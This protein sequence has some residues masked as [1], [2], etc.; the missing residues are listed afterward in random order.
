M[1]PEG[2]TVTFQLE[3]IEAG[4]HP[5]SAGA[6][7]DFVDAEGDTGRV[8]F[9]VDEVDVSDGPPGPEAPGIG[10]A[11]E[12][13]KHEL[14]V[15]ER[16]AGSLAVDIDLPDVPGRTH[17]MLVLDA[18]G[19]M[20]GEAL[21][22][23][24]A[25]V[26]ALLDRLEIEAN[27]AF[28]AGLVTFNTVA[29]LLCP[30]SSDFDALRACVDV[31]E[32]AGGTSLSL[33]LALASD[34]LVAGRPSPGKEAIVLMSDGAN[35]TGCE[36]VLSHA[37]AI[38]ADGATIHT[39][40]LGPA[41][42]RACM[43]SAA[44]SPAHHHVVPL[45]ADLATAYAD[46][47]AEL[48]SLRP[49]ERAFLRLDLPAHL[50]FDPAAFAPPPDEISEQRAIWDIRRLRDPTIDIRF[51]VEALSEGSGAPSASVRIDFENGTQR[52]EPADGPSI[53][54]GAAG[55]STATPR[56]TVPV[57]P[58]SSPPTTPGTPTRVPP[59]GKTEVPGSTIFL[60]ISL[61][62]SCISWHPAD[63]AIVLDTSTS[64]GEISPDGVAKID[65]ARSAVQALIDGLVTGRD[66]VGLVAFDEG[67][68]VLHP[69]AAD[70]GG[71]ARALD[72][73][74]LGPNTVIDAG[75]DEARRMLLD[76][77]SGAD[78]ERG[79]S[80]IVLLTDGRPLPGPASAAVEAAERARSDGIVFFV[81][82]LGPEIDGPALIAIA[83][84]PDAYRA[85]DGRA[86]LIAAFR[87]VG[88]W[89]D[90]GPP[91]GFWG[92]RSA[93]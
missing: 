74:T 8:D 28:R 48:L 82:G 2:V 76:G 54:V 89:I 71:I 52:T 79:V 50:S 29:E 55:P 36:P 34:A 24:K 22:V 78:P 49:V 30:L 1:P 53:V 68:R 7:A 39:V 65:G 43:E 14:A 10:A 5:T 62:E 58:S 44:T 13:D 21:A 63:I 6:T 88:R 23:Q 26:H 47:S 45:P 35:S 16:S 11:L 75:I 19:S 77:A 92:R 33:G 42:D 87:T 72:E 64:M 81:V 9:P 60:P 51:V 73:I 90:C 40:C 32:A 46:V 18:S 80:I 83:D 66:R 27:P 31:M 57:S 84:G 38:K 91:A 67:A 69:L 20:L 25:S 3:A 59:S 37:D 85:A 4:R 70:L 12:I 61:R 56:P 86:A 41:C 93:E 17:L 15:G